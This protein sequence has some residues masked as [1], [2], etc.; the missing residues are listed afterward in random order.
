VTVGNGLEFQGSGIRRSAL[1]GDVTASAGSNTTT[2]ANTAVT[3]AEYTAPTI[4]VDS[5]GRITAAESVTYETPAGA[6]AQIEAAIE[7]YSVNNSLT[8]IVNDDDTVSGFAVTEIADNQFN[9]AQIKAAQIGSSVTSIGSSAFNYCT[10]LTNI[11][12]PDSVTS[13]GNYAF[14]TCT[15]L[16]SIN[17]PDSVTSIGDAAFRSCSSLTNITIPDGV[18]SIGH[19]AFQSCTSLTTVGLGTGITSIGSVAFYYCTSLASITIPDSVTSI[20]NYAFNTCTSLTSI[21]SP[22]PKTVW[23]AATGSLAGTASP[24]TIHA[25]ASDASWTAGTG[26][27]VAGNTNVTVVKDL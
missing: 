3:A 26:L 4:T 6:A 22:I 13:I 18:L 9:A 14:N 11:T 15:S 12:I 19:Y 8:L 5:K 24:L 1:T 27:T 23:D 16:S 2:L 21:N 7:D 20:G 25:L 10:S 17:I